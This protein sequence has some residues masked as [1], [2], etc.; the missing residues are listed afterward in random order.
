MRYRRPIRLFALAL[1]P[2]LLTSGCGVPGPPVP[3]VARI[4]AVPRDLAAQQVGER[5]LLRWTLPRL[6]T[7][8]AR[9]DAYPR[10]EVHR[11]FLGEGTD[12]EVAF[13]GAAQVVYTIPGQVVDTFL[14]DGVVVFPDVV[15]P[16]VL[17][18][19]AGRRAAYAVQAVNAKGQTAGFSNLASVR[20]YPV[21][22]PIRRLEARV[23]ERAIV[24]TWPSP[25]RTTSDT[26]LEALAGYQVYR[27]P[28]GAEG[29]F[30]LHGTAPTARYEDTQFQFGQRYFYRVRTLAQYG[31]DVVESADSVTTDVLATD[32]FAPPVPVDLIV[33]AGSGRVDLTWDASAAPDLAGYHVY[34]A[35]AADGEYRRLNAQLLA[36]QSFSDSVDLEPGRE[37]YYVVTAVDREGNESPFSEPVA[38]RPLPSE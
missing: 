26:P 12:P 19:Q 37:Y 27:S 5:V 6:Y 38:G 31:R 21:A 23:T 22:S 18:E 17:K 30:V 10:V 9:M 34:R 8:G 33:V 36:A 14:H 1:L 29:S 35:T 32:V 25:E 16:A 24:L 2:L 7:D 11:A 4:P 28:S 15:A 20:I 3:P 13:A